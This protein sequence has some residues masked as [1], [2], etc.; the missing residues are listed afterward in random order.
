MKT[1]VARPRRDESFEYYWRY[2][3]RVPGEDAA[4]A[5]G[6]QGD[7]TLALLARLD[8]RAA[9][10]RYA[11][12]KWSIKEVLGHM[13]DTERVMSYRALR[14]GR[15]DATPLAGFDENRYVPAAGCDRRP[16]DALRGELRVVRAATLSL[17][18][19]FD[20]EALTRRG[21]AAGQPVTVR[22]LLWIIAGHELHHLAVL[23]ERYGIGG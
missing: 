20:A 13:A 8:D 22:A 23:R 18:D 11:P 19:S 7:A 17:L 21:E 3:D 1:V 5:L 15:D 12:G 6:A 9:L 14:I 16:L 10:H 2:I 4:A